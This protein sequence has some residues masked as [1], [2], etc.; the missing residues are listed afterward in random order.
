MLI[1][2]VINYKGTAPPQ[3]IAAGFDKVGGSIGRGDLNAL[4]LPDADRHIS[5]MHARISYR[6]GRYVIEDHGSATPVIVNG[7]PLG[8]GMDATLAHGDEIT[9]GEYRLRSL[10]QEAASAAF[11]AGNTSVIIGKV[12][13]PVDALE[14]AALTTAPALRVNVGVN[15]ARAN[16]IPATV[17]DND[18]L[19]ETQ[20][21]E[22]TPMVHAPAVHAFLEGAGI[23]DLDLPTAVAPQ[24]MQV[25][26]QVLRET[27]QT[28][29]QML[30][31][32]DALNRELSAEGG[33]P[34]ARERNPLKF[35][36]SVEAALSHLLNPQRGA[37][38]PL[39]AVKDACNDLRSHQVAS[40]TG[41][42]AALAEIVHRFNLQ[43]LA[44][45][46]ETD[47]HA[48]FEREF[49]KAYETH[50]GKPSSPGNDG[51]QP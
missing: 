20:R 34:L 50:R 23:A 8:R 48:L 38:P 29:R 14:R 46:A 41:M 47:F 26:G 28:M 51:K 44:T 1:L 3:P 21:F 39:D 9:I 10:L 40:M 11:M 22:R 45:D 6:S 18:P 42:S 30:S 16:P 43:P 12:R 15:A 24:T 25:L 32:Q 36:P 27:L 4:M 35:A 2:E 31:V 13:S 37:M 49:L 7:N 5:R 19:A 17:L 33:K